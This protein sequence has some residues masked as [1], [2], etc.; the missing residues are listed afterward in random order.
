MSLTMRGPLERELMDDT[1]RSLGVANNGLAQRFKQP[2]E[3]LRKQSDL[4]RAI[5]EARLSH[6][7]AR[8]GEAASERRDASGPCATTIG[9]LRSARLRCPGFERQFPDRQL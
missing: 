2:V 3:M 6:R 4:G 9:Y 8:S 1:R 7:P 5:D